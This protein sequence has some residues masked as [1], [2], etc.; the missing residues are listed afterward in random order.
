MKHLI[1]IVFSFSALFS[2]KAQIGNA[3]FETWTQTGA[4]E[5]P[6]GWL[7]ANPLLAIIPFNTNFTTKKDADATDGTYAALLHSQHYTFVGGNL[8][9]VVTTGSIDFDMQTGDV[10]FYGGT[11]FAYRP[12]AISFDFKYYPGM[13]TNAI[14]DSAFGFAVLTKWN[15]SLSSL[16]TIAFAYMLMTDSSEYASAELTFNYL[17]NDTPDSLL[18]TFSS[19]INDVS[20]QD[21]SMLWLDKFEVKFF[22]GVKKPLAEL[23]QPILYPNPAREMVFLR[24]TS[25]QVQQVAVY[26]M[27]GMQ[28][29]TL[30]LNPGEGRL[31][32]RSWDAGVYLYRISSVEGKLLNNGKFT[33]IR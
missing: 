33:V 29:A 24:N 2:A 31:S 27:L 8:P 26:N 23:K 21:G 4:Y 20:A 22:T 12:E 13:D 16:D 14:M 9:G 28:M 19:S 11:P 25:Q 32:V 17:S 10:S 7:T 6:N 3:S 30:T 5:Q 15:T 1:L 18:L